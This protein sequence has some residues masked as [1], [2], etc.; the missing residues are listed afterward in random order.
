MRRATTK[1]HDEILSGDQATEGR[2]M[3]GIRRVRAPSPRRGDGARARRPSILATPD[4][5][6]TTS[7]TVD[8]GPPA[9]QAFTPRTARW[10]VPGPI[11]LLTLR[12][13]DPNVPVNVPVTSSR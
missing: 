8:D 11:G 1:R 13:A 12:P 4:R 5:Y 7:V 6:G 2:R 9:P 10:Y 3:G